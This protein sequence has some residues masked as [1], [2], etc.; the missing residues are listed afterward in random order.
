MRRRIHDAATKGTTVV[1]QYRIDDVHI[2]L[3]VPFGRQVGLS[4]GLE[5]R[6]TVTTETYGA[7]G[8]LRS[9]T[10]APFATSFVVGPAHG[11]ALAQRGRAAAEVDGMRGITVKGPR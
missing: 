5:S 2:T 9:R 3:L 10:S 4:L 7:G 11:W 6:G 1:E 8:D